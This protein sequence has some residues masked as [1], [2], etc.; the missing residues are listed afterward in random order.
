LSFDPGP[1]W[2][3]YVKN[4][5][6]NQIVIERP[7]GQWSTHHSCNS[8]IHSF[9][10][11]FKP[12]VTSCRIMDALLWTVFFFGGGGGWI[13]FMKE[14]AL[15]R[16][17]FMTMQR[18]STPPSMCNDIGSSYKVRWRNNVLKK[19]AN[20]PCLDSMKIGRWFDGPHIYVY[21][22]YYSSYLDKLF[23]RKRRRKKQTFWH[24]GWHCQPD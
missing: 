8:I 24:I 17:L 12:T 20:R 6:F 11:L 23:N 9:T 22:I 19:M 2:K 16:F 14:V 18:W 1:N 5:Q 15:H 4:I 21:V 10:N 13:P 7:C 3:R